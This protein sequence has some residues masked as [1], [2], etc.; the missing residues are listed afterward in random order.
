[1]GGKRYADDFEDKEWIRIINSKL[2][3]GQPEQRITEPAKASEGVK[4][5]LKIRRKNIFRKK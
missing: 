2:K 5:S 3:K 1:M 4:S